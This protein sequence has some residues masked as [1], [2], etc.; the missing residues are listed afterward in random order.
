MADLIEFNMKGMR[1]LS[2][3]LVG[4]RKA[5]W[6]RV[7]FVEMHRF[8]RVA[9]KVLQREAP[10]RRLPTQLTYSVER[11]AP[12]GYALRLRAEGYDPDI[13]KYIVRGTRP[14]TIVPVRARALR[15]Y[16]KKVGRIVFFKRVFHPGT[17]ANPFIHRTVNRLMVS[18]EVERVSRRIAEGAIKLMVKK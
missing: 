12:E 5:F 17:R 2:G 9:L 1:D 4:A 6:D 18:G 8:G 10:G 7:V 16:W 13:L 3:S 15:F 11:V 14:H